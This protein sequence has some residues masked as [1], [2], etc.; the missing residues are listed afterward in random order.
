MQFDREVWEKIVDKCLEYKIDTI[1]LSLGEGLV[2][3]SHPELAVEGSW[4]T[5]EMKSEVQRLKNLGIKM[6]PK[7]NFSAYHD[8]W[9]GEYGKSL[10]STPTYYRVCKDLIEEVYELFDHPEYIHLGLDEEFPDYANEKNHFRV[11]DKL[12]EDYR[13]LIECVKATG[14]KALMWGSICGYY[15]D[16]WREYI[17]KDVVMGKGQY[18]K[19]DQS[20]WT[21]VADQSDWVRGYYWGGDFEKRDLYREYALKYGDKPIEY[22]EQDPVVDKVIN[23][24]RKNITEGYKLI[25][26]A[27]NVFL[28]ANTR[29]TVKYYCGSDLEEGIIG[30][31]GCSWKPTIKENE[32]AILEEIELLEMVQKLVVL[33]MS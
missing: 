5:E 9:L 2:Y 8:P 17:D 32:E 20:K 10:I 18:Y 6:I 12:F 4:T 23:S 14:A 19:Y 21:K 27:S 11:G 13:Y 16:L 7:F 24:I 3:Q 25:I 1:V 26:I 33:L 28:K 30:Y 31:L 15:E 22:I 29:S